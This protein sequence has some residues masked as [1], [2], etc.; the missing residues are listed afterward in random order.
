MPKILVL[1]RLRQEDYEFK[2]SLGHTAGSGNRINKSLCQIVGRNSYGNS[3]DPE[4]PKQFWQ[5][6]KP[7]HQYL[8]ILKLATEARQHSKEQTHG[9]MKQS[10]SRNKASH[11]QPTDIYSGPKITQLRTDSVFIRRHCD[12]QTFTCQ[13]MELESCHV[14]NNLKMDQRPNGSS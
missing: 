9:S 14:K 12:N 6:A 8:L 11:F 10:R 5:R 2:A 7:K 4:K 13:R 3:R 1:L